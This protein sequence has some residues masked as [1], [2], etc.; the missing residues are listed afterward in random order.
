MSKNFT[1]YILLY[2]SEKSIDWV[3][4]EIDKFDVNYIHHIYLVDNKSM[5]T[6]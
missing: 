2:N 5:I 6:L 3:F 1:I 4:D